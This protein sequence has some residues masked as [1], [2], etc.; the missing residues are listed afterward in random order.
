MARTSG[1]ETTVFNVLAFVLECGM[2][3]AAV[4]FDGRMNLDMLFNANTGFRLGVEYDGA[5]WHL[6]QESRDFRKTQR[7]LGT[8]FVH[9]VIRLREEPLALLGP[10]DVSVPRG[11]TGQEVAD[12]ALLHLG[13]T[14]G[15]AFGPEVDDH[16]DFQ[17]RRL[18][19]SADKDH[20]LCRKC[21][22]LIMGP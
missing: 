15:H 9:E 13:H 7:L 12:R 2:Q 6:G 18:S 21:R 22:R 16:L 14:V 1:I 11:T 19:L 3:D 4:P 10:L 17:I 20:F 5:Y 8:G